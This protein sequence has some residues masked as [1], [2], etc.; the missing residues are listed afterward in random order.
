MG[1]RRERRRQVRGTAL[2]LVDTTSVGSCGGLEGLVFDRSEVGEAALSAAAMVVA[3]D[4]DH[5][6]V[7]EFGGARSDLAGQ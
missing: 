3:F 1:W 6:G 7:A 5:D 2:S 4:P